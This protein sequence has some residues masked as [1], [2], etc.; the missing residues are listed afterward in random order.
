MRSVKAVW[1]NVGLVLVIIAAIRCGSY[2]LWLWQQNE[3][4]AAVGV[5]LFTALAVALPFFAA[6]MTGM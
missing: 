6:Y 1:A 2:G 3:R 4:R 5:A